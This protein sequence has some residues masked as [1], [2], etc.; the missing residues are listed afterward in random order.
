MLLPTAGLVACASSEPP[1]LSPV[2]FSGETDLVSH[3]VRSGKLLSPLANVGGALA[4]AG[5]ASTAR[6]GIIVSPSQPATD[7]KACFRLICI[8][9]PRIIPVSLLSTNQKDPGLQSLSVFPK[10][11]QVSFPD[12]A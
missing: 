4:F 5:A 11:A 6:D 7:R 3:S 9:F 1:P 10:A 2:G 12:S 8:A